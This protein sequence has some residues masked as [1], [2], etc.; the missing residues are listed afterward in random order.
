MTEH[1][2]SLVVYIDV[3]ETLV[4]NYGKTRIPMPASIRHVRALFLQGATLYCWSSGGAA[5]A[6][7]SA[8]ELGIE[9]CFQGFLPKPHVLLDDQNVSEWRRLL[10]I[11]PN[12]FNQYTLESYRA[13]LKAQR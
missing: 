9:D 11:H 4:R 10:Q 7:Q 3:D 6:R 13:L 12:A 8:Q 5:Y 2:P 1:R